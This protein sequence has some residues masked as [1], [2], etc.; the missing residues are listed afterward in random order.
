MTARRRLVDLQAYLIQ[1]PCPRV[2]VYCQTM[3]GYSPLQLQPVHSTQAPEEQEKGSSSRH[4]R[5][6][7]VSQ[8]E[9][10]N[11]L[12]LLKELALLRQH[13]PLSA[14][15]MQQQALQCRHTPRTPPA[16]MPMSTAS[17]HRPR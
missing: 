11:V 13:D 4:K 16:L 3:P 1:D 15:C 9:G 14:T 6:S 17:A 5:D 10:W 7:G 2:H 12:G 8:V